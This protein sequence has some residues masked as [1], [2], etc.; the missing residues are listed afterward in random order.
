MEGLI[1]QLGVGVVRI[2][3]RG[4]L[5]VFD[6]AMRLGPMRGAALLTY[7]PFVAA[8]AAFL[9]KVYWLDGVI[10]NTLTTIA[11]FAIFALLGPLMNTG[12][13]L[14][15][16]GWHK[17]RFGSYPGQKDQRLHPKGGPSP[18]LLWVKTV[19]DWAE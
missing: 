3:V 5:A 4:Y 11:V 8:S 6:A 10:D 7:G 2:M 18:T 16:E 19:R 13:K 17:A 9:A 1:S 12:S 15:A 14:L